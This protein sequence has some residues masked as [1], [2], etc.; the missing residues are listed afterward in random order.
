MRYYVILLAMV[1]ISC[2]T[3]VKE[4]TVVNDLDIQLDTIAVKIINTLQNENQLVAITEFTD[5]KGSVSELG[6][7]IAEEL[8]TKLYQ[9]SKLEI[10]ERQMFKKILKEQNLGLTGYIDEQTAVSIGNILGADAIVTGTITVIGKDIRI[11]ARV[12]S[13]KTGKVLSAASASVIKDKDLVSM[14][15]TGINREE[16][17]SSYI[18]SLYE[19]DR[20]NLKIKLIQ[21]EVKGR[22]LYCDFEITNNGPD[23]VKFE[24]TYGWQYKTKV[25]DQNSNETIVSAVKF[26]S[27]VTKIKGLSQYDGASKKIIA[28]STAEMTLVFD[29]VDPDIKKI[30]LL[31]I[32]SGNTKEKY[33]FRD[34]PIVSE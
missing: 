6:L 17:I 11:N 23:D 30:L 18:K 33:E 8:T 22:T 13:A 1:I 15:E 20:N 24:V 10:V 5:V 4:T 34:I 12:I 3:A 29:K 14:L 21:A 16:Q 25:F 7:Y 32:L 19:I 31:Q 2:S 27:N 9:K 28:G 26:G